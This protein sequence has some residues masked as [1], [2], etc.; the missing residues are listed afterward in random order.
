[1]SQQIKKK[2]IA[3]KAVDGEKI[4]LESGQSIKHKISEN[5]VVD[6]IRYDAQ[7]RVMIATGEAATKQDILKID[8]DVAA[9]LFESE[10]DKNSFAEIVS[11]I[12][13]VDD[14]NDEALNTYMTSNNLRVEVLEDDLEEL[15]SL[16]NCNFNLYLDQADVD[17]GYFDFGKNSKTLIEGSVRGYIGRV[18]IHPDIDFSV[19]DN[20]DGTY[21]VHFIDEMYN[22]SSE[23]DVL[24]NPKN[25]SDQAPENGDRIIIYFQVKT[26]V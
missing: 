25:P 20:G 23:S 6:L 8:T 5:N 19:S 7:G 3:D 12:N 24:G 16:Q 11:Y 17:N 14:D 2:F 10:D 18:A 22:G 1:M 13:D 4:E 15:S 9:I 21:R 26:L